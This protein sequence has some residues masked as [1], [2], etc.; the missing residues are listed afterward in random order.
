[1]WVA[2][3]PG[4]DVLYNWDQSKASA[5]A[6][7]IIPLWFKGIL[8]SDGGPEVLCFLKGGKD[9]Q[10]PPRDIRRADC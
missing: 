9:R 2:T 5:V 3:V 4:G 1:M 7:G 6:D 8:Q 10:K